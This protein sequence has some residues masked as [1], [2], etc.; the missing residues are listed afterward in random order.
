MATPQSLLVSV[1]EMNSKIHSANKEVV[2]SLVDVKTE[3]HKHGYVL[4]DK[5]EEYK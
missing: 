3:L 4:S 1:E 2:S 5:C